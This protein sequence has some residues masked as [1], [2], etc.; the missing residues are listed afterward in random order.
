M[1]NAFLGLHVENK[2]MKYSSLTLA[3]K[4]NAVL[5]SLKSVCEF[6]LFIFLARLI[7]RR[8]IRILIPCISKIPFPTA[9]A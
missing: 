6:N 2:S 9:T 4:H 8:V 3:Q 7:E 1:Q 5:T